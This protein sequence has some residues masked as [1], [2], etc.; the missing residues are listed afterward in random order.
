MR[1]TRLNVI[2]LRVIDGPNA[3]QIR[4]RSMHF[5]HF[6]ASP[7]EVG[8]IRVVHTKLSSNL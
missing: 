3:R 7:N 8:Y 1:A 5:T 4:L 2:R 6:S